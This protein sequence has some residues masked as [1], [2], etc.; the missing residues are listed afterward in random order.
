LARAEQFSDFVLQFHA[1]KRHNENWKE[2]PAAGVQL[3]DKWHECGGG[4]M[5]G[6][7]CG[8][9]VGN[10]DR[11]IAMAPRRCVEKEFVPGGTAEFA[12]QVG[13]QEIGAAI[14]CGGIEIKTIDGLRTQ[15][16]T[17]C[18]AIEKRMYG[19][20]G[21][22][23]REAEIEQGCSALAAAGATGGD[24]GCGVATKVMPRVCACGANVQR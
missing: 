12:A 15:L 21:A 2:R 17:E 3:A 9:S 5:F 18:V 24:A 13:A 20:A 6:G 22:G 23:V 19:V 14:G 8:E 10:N 4:V 1:G 11:K 7:L 16:A